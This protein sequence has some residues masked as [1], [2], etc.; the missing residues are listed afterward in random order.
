MDAQPT[1]PRRK[2]PLITGI[3]PGERVLAVLRCPLDEPAW[4]EL[5]ASVERGD[6]APVDSRVHHL[7]VPD[8]PPSGAPTPVRSP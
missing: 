6:W 8:D 2:A 5:E 1:I 4:A 7:T 3:R